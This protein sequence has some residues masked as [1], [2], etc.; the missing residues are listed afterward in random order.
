MYQEFLYDDIGNTY[1]RKNL[2]F[3][4][5]SKLQE[6]IKSATP[7]QKSA[8]KAELKELKRNKNKHSYNVELHSFKENEKIFLKELREKTKSMKASLKGKHSRRVTIL[9]T[10][11]Y[12]FQLK[13]NFYQPFKD[14]TYDNVLIFEEAKIKSEQLKHT[15][16]Q[17]EENEKALESAK[18][19]LHSFDEVYNAKKK[20]ELKVLKAFE[21][22]KFNKAK[23][24]LKEKKKS[25]LISEKA[26]SNGIV[27][28]KKQRKENIVVQYYDIPKHAAKEKIKSYR[29][30]LRK[31]T[32]R[33]LSV[34]ESNVADVRRKTPT[35][36]SKTIPVNAFLTFWLPGLGQVL[37]GQWIKSILFF[38]MSAFA[39]FVAIPYALGYSNFQG[40]GI[41]GLIS[42]AEG[43][44]KLDRSLIFM[45]EGIIAIFLIIFTVVILVIAFKDVLSVEKKKIKGVRPKNWFETKTAV[46]EEGFPYLVSLP[47][48]VA[49][50]FIVLVPIAT[51]ILLSFTNM[52]PNHQNKFEW[53]GLANYKLI[54][55]GEGIA[56]GPFWNILGWTLIWTIFATSL[57]IAIGF[58]LAILANNERIKAKTFFRA[59]YLLPWAVPAFITIMFFSIMFSRNG[60]L[61]GYLNNIFNFDT[62]IA[63]KDNP[64][65]SRVTLISLQGWLGSAYVFL[66]S[67]GVLQA[68]PADLY[69]AAQIDGATAWQKLRKITL[70]IVLFQTAPLLV[71][72]YTFNFNNFSIIYLFNGGGPFNPSKYGNLAGSTDLLISYIFKL[73]TQ[74]DYQAIG[75]AIT[76]VISL[77]LMLFA[78]IGFKNSKAFKEE[79]L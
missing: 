24:A 70:P 29:Y 52:D 49:I 6:S 44:K 20:D 51:A 39:Y 65:W 9:K 28:L 8:V 75:A 71:G 41:A 53:I 55:L 61:T 5:V 45:I 79:K 15:I 14:L 76:I 34:I 33:E 18:K 12:R 7:E 69:E 25:G 32:Q 47:A 3:K 21:K 11:Q 4:E 74:Y 66:L 16:I 2:Y 63:V 73:T 59:V 58:G 19:E 40:K 64:F 60:I 68:I 42:L 78:F 35:E 48:L 67:T 26:L 22:E 30:Q 36:V 43:G 46:F 56:G 57:A 10:K 13:E 38:V 37:N 23:Q 1:E 17:V 62:P 77:G 72:Q 54:A 31:G 50:V 27:E